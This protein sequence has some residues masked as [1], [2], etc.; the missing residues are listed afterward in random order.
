MAAD[1]DRVW[2]HLAKTDPYWAVLTLPQFHKDQLTK[3]ALADFFST[4]ERHVEFVLDVIHSPFDPSFTPWACLDFGC[5]VGRLVIPFAQKCRAVVGV[6]VSEA[7][8]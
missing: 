5:G 4:G 1:T 2:N 7:M 8:L 6:D 3:D